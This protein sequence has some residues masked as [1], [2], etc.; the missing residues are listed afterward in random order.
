MKVKSIYD[1]SLIKCVCFFFHYLSVIQRTET[2]CLNL[3]ENNNLLFCFGCGRVVGYCLEGAS[4]ILVLFN[5]RSKYYLTQRQNYSNN[6]VVLLTSSHERDQVVEMLREQNAQY[7][8]YEQDDNDYGN[9][10]PFDDYGKNNDHEYHSANIVIDTNNDISRGFTDVAHLSDISSEQTDD[11]R[12]NNEDFDAEYDYSAS[13][14]PLESLRTPGLPYN[15]DPDTFMSPSREYR[16]IISPD[17]DTIS[18]DNYDYNSEAEYDSEDNAFECDSIGL[19]DDDFE[20][21]DNYLMNRYLND[22]FLSDFDDELFD[23]V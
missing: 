3:L 6:R 2:N 11:F 13:P 1:V 10:E 8:Q 16:G 9:Y 19:D 4:S 23:H 7:N 12:D 20:I 18:E 5:V 17:Y 15:N 14:V 22:V 21:P